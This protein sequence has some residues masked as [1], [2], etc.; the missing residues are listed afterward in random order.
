M[1]AQG[2]TEAR[3]PRR[4]LKG[5]VQ[6][7]LRSLFQGAIVEDLAFLLACEELR[8]HACVHS[9]AT[10]SID[11]RAAESSYWP[12][13]WLLAAFSMWPRTPGAGTAKGAGGE[14]LREHIE[15]EGVRRTSAQV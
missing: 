8:K 5:V 15:V 3:E 4:G 9:H 11:D 6:N 7:C 14:K 10:R 13:E 12:V 1:A 2:R